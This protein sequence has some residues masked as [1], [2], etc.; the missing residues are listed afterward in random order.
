MKRM[1]SEENDKLWVYQEYDWAYRYGKSAK[2][3]LHQAFNRCIDRYG[4]APNA[5]YI[6]GYGEYIA[7]LD[8]RERYSK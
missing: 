3:G 2:H 1:T 7:E 4:D 8:R 6:S 5:G